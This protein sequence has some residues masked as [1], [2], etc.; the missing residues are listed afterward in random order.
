MANTKISA[1]TA[2]AG[3]AVDSAA[4]VLAIVDT[5]ASL[6]KKILT[7][8]VFKANQVQT[9]TPALRFSSNDLVVTYSTQL[10]RYVQIGNLVF[11]GFSITTASFVWLLS[12]GAL[13]ITGLPINDPGTFNVAFDIQWSGITKAGYT[14]IDGGLAQSSIILRA[15]GSGKS[16]S[17]LTTT[18]FPSGGTYT[19]NGSMCYIA[20]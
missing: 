4:D 5:S 11:I 2:L 9:W 7:S 16:Q 14:Q 6:E 3:S 20:A 10:G 13:N 18:D 15:S 19:L 17:A 8:E 12:S 1:L